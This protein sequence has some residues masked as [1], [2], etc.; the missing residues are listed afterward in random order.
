MFLP[1]IFILI[2]FLRPPP[3]ASSRLS[4]PFLPHLSDRPLPPSLPSVTAFPAICSA[5]SCYLRHSILPAVSVFSVSCSALSSRLCHAVLPA[6][7]VFSVNC[8]A[9]SY[10]LRHGILPAVSD[11]S[12]C[13]SALSSRLCHAVLLSSPQYP[14]SCPSLS[15]RMRLAVL[16]SHMPRTCK[17]FSPLYYPV[18]AFLHSRTCPS[19]SENM[20]FLMQEKPLLDARKA[21]SRSILITI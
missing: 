12:V 17:H 2:S 5:P 16:V 13:C 20:P 3:P 7:P 6:V 10:Y 18:Y 8:S 9:L 14:A 1:I 15:Y 21:Y 11:F 4:S 19:T